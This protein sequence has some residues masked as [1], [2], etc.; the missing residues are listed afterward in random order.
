[1]QRWL[2]EH[3]IKFRPIPPRSPHLNGKVS[4][5]SSLTYRNSGRGYRRSRDHG[6]ANPGMAVR[7]QLA[8]SSR[9]AQK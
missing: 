6:T 2:M 3:C 9:L 4:A 1:V 7:L 5:R 8:P